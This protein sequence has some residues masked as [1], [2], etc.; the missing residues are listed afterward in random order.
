M[1]NISK[2]L[3]NIKDENITL[4]DSSVGNDGVTRIQATLDYVPKACEHCGS[5][6]EGQITKYGWRKTTVR[7]PRAIGSTVILILKRRYFCCKEDA[8]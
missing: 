1:D 5:V 4:I 2:D 3:L 8:G 7:Y 6:N